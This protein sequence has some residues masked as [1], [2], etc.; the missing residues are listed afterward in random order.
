MMRYDKY[1]GYFN[2]MI[3][4]IQYVDSMISMLIIKWWCQQKML[5][6]WDF[7]NKKWC[8]P[9]D[10]PKKSSHDEPRLDADD[11]EL[12][13][14]D[15]DQETGGTWQRG[16]LRVALRYIQEGDM[17]DILQIYDI[18]C[19]YIYTLGEYIYIIN[20]YIYIHIHL[21]H[22]SYIYIYLYIGWYA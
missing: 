19:I 14:V 21:L 3:F 22:I 11:G 20:S 17:I 9:W 16:Q 12:V 6:N 2:Y 15:Q 7:P 1:V 13:H 8:F 10:F 4:C 5:E 18:W